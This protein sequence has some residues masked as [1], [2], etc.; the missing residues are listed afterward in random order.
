MNPSEFSEAI[1][2]PGVYLLDLRPEA[3]FE[4]AHIA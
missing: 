2:K 1:K 3:D 4:K